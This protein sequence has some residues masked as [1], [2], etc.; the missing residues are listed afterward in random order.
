M[1]VSISEAEVRLDELIERVEA[2]EE[3][4]LTRDGHAVVEMVRARRREGLA[5]SQRFLQRNETILGWRVPQAYCS[6]IGRRIT[7]PSCSLA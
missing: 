3:V 2:G 6:Q 4:I 1:Q 7:A 5:R